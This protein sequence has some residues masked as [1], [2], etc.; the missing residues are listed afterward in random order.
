MIVEVTGP[1]GAGKSTYLA[2]LLRTL[3][4]RGVAAGAIHSAAL[5]RSAMIPDVF[6]DLENQNLS[7]DI[8]AF[9][10]ALLL[11]LRYPR[12]LI[13]CLECMATIDE[14]LREKI[15]IARSFLRKAGIYRFLSRRK[16]QHMVVG[17]DE[18][19]FHSAHNL[20]SSARGLA[21]ENRI[22]RFAALCP[23][24][25]AIIVLTAPAE[26][27]VERLE[28]RG[29]LSPRIRRK[30]D[31]R[32]FTANA[33]AMFATLA[34][35]PRLQNR[36][37]VIDTGKTDTATALAMSLDLLSRQNTSITPENE[38]N[39]RIENDCTIIGHT[40]FDSFTER[41]S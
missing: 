23:L 40:L 16:F 15:A 6:C 17:V 7:T 2:I 36:R 32:T 29:D 35:S 12:F 41:L 11:F 37:I 4:D 1:S 31:I 13:F 39:G 3:S 33:C 28:K 38:R 30:K 14:P 18:G 27:L 5:N 8:C 20:L 26:L 24:P 10:W 25:D 34:C 22:K 19:L 21:G 9:S